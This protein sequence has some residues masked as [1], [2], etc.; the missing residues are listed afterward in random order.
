[1][2]GPHPRLAPPEEE[3][4]RIPNGVP[5]AMEIPPPSYSSRTQLKPRASG[6]RRRER[7]P[8]SVRENAG[9][10]TGREEKLPY[11]ATHG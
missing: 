10:E 5:P 4:G 9:K 2:D 6:R 8:K 3:K 7:L 11:G 1:M